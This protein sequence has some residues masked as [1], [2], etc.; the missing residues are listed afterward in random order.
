[1]SQKGDFIGLCMA[2]AA[3]YTLYGH[4]VR[5]AITQFTLFDPIPKLTSSRAVCLTISTIHDYQGRRRIDTNL[6]CKRD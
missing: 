2:W 4:V 6:K 3:R 1:M 5:L